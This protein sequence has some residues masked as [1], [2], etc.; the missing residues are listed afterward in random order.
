M[1]IVAI[2]RQ[3]SQAIRVVRAVAITRQ[4]LHPRLHQLQLLH[5]HQLLHLSLHQLLHLSQSQMY[6]I[7]LGKVHQIIITQL[8]EVVMLLRQEIMQVF[9]VYGVLIEFLLATLRLVQDSQ[10]GY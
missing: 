10:F 8:V 7:A 2:Q 6:G 3:L 5:R 4:L 9:A 1:E